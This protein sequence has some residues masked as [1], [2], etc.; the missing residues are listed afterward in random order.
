MANNLTFND[1]STL[2]VSI[3]EQ[4]TGQRPITPVTTGDFIAVAQATLKTGYDTVINSISQVLSRTIF[5]VRPYSRKFSG[6]YMDAQRWGNHTR[7]LQVIDKNPEQDVRYNLPADGESVDQQVLNKPEVLQTNYYG[8]EVYQ[9]SVT[10]FK[11][12]LDCAFSTPE[13]FGAFISMVMQNV[14]DLIEKDHENCA[15]MTVANLIGGLAHYNVNTDYKNGVVHLVSEYNDITGLQ[16]DSDTV[17]QPDN[18]VP[19]M[20]WAFA[21]IK[22]VSD[23]LTERTTAYHFNITDKP[24]A[25]HT[26]KDRQKCYMYA[27][28]INN[29][30][31]SVLSSVFNASYLEN[32]DFETVNY[33]QSIDTPTGVQV[34]PAILNADGS[35][36]KA[37]ETVVANVLGVIFDE[38]AAGI[39]TV[40]T[41]TASAPFN[42]R[43][44]YTNTFWHF[45]DRYFN[46]FTEN[47]VLFLMD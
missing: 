3:N 8:A 39:T 1:L 21:R 2:L 43:G 26:P 9:R 45:T 41:W 17:K 33:W 47:A 16:L 42:A 34:N 31:A 15:R 27:G 19:F 46:D 38:D 24:I 13:E 18:F 5:S 20:K 11:D 30:E 6:L 28:D 14:S 37:G 25:R 10:M 23:L 12:Q 44:G 7:K 29:M 40:N 4:A 32:V 22:S 36:S 35:V